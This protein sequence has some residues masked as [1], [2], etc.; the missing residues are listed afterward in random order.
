MF[1]K[2]FMSWDEYKERVDFIEYF[3]WQQTVR[4]QNL[5]A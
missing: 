5:E 4:K 3:L 1:R 2:G